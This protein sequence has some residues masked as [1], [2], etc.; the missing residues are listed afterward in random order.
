MTDSSLTVKISADVTSLQAQAAVA[1][2]ELS[3]LNANVKSLAAQFVE[4]SDEMKSSLAPQL[5]AAAQKA[6]AVKTELA[7]LNAEMKETVHPE[8]TGFF[9]QLGESARVTGESIESLHA[10]ISVFSNAIGAFSE[11]LFAGLALEQVGETI[12]KVA[13]QGEQLEKLSQ[14]TGLT[15]EQLSGLRVMAIETGT[16]F[17]QFTTLLD[18]LP[19]TMQDA[20]AGTGSAAEA[21]TAMGI[22]V[23]DANGQLRPMADVLDEVAAKLST[24]ADGTN[25][26][27]LETDIFGAKIGAN[28]IPMLNQLGQEGLQGAIQ[29]SNELSQTWSTSDAEAAEKFEEDLSTVKLG[30]EGIAASIVKVALPALDQLAQ[31]FSDMTGTASIDDQIASMQA[32]LN[33]AEHSRGRFNSSASVDSLKADLA[34]LEA[35]KKVITDSAAAQS[36]IVGGAAPGSVQAP[37]VNNSADFSKDNEAALAQQNAQIE[38]SASSTKEANQEKLQN[39]VQYWQGVLQAGNLTSAEELTAQTQLAKAETALKGNELSAGTSSAKSA[40]SQETQIAAD[41][42]EARKEI[43][44]SEYQ[45]KVSQWD[46]EVSRNKITKAQEIQDEIAAENQM[47]QAALSE[48]NQEAALDTAGSEAKAKALDDI[49]VITAAHDAEIAKL[50]NDLVT[51]QIEDA[52]NLTDEQQKAAAATSEAWQKAFQP[53]GQAFDSSLNGILQGT[54]TLQQAEA[55]AAQSILLSFIDAEG[56]K[57]ANY[58]AGEAMILARGIAT[59]LGLT[60]ATQSGIAIQQASKTAA[61]ATGRTEDIALGTAQI[62]SSAMRAAAGAYS[63]VAGIPYV[64]PFLAPAAAATAY[65]GVMAFDVLS[66]AGGMAIPG[67]VNPLTQLHENEMV[68]PAHIAQPLQNMIA[69]GSTT[70]SNSSSMQFNYNQ[71]VHGGRGS[72]DGALLQKSNKQ[73]VDLIVDLTRNGTLRLPGR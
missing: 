65:A 57:V 56:K 35:Q 23:T 61:D 48:A 3:D 73:L 34:S 42:A 50:N 52:K 69:G 66:A 22:K 5:D 7:A 8:V 51:Q 59:Q 24:Y 30:I 45:Q 21:F 20:A 49:Q 26:T 15:T 9:G 32:S 33:N 40:A 47:Y 16:D 41:A 43:A 36:T 1:K 62:N 54:Q 27:A 71:T 18:R 31:A 28:L 2:A 60:A 14:E 68:L 44:S 39:T 11:F 38:A 25:K 10:R 53:I 6:A 46:A 63:A 12:N 67:G 72:V 29:K 37:T 58:M 13:E 64:G 17:S 70:N 55:K 19:K 4:A